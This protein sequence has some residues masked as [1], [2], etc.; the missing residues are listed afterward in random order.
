MFGRNEGMWL[1]LQGG[2]GVFM[3]AL[4]RG[5]WGYSLNGLG[6]DESVSVGLLAF[7]PVILPTC[8]LLHASIC[9]ISLPVYLSIYVTGIL[10][11]QSVDIVNVPS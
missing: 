4:G 1:R 11:S 5:G 7:L 10:T 2:A 6:V 3:S 9:R 8:C